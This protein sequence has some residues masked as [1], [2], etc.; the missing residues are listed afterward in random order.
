MASKNKKEKLLKELRS[1]KLTIIKSRF[2]KHRWGIPEGFD[3]N[4]YEENIPRSYKTRT[5]CSIYWVDYAFRIKI[6]F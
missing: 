5:C 3:D 2:C 1:F 4:I 6:L